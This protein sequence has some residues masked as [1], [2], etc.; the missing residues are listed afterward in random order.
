VMGTDASKSVVNPDFQVHG[1]QTLYIAD[2]SI[3]PNAPGINPGLTI[4]SL[5]HRLATQ[6]LK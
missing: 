1:E 4:K 2:S 5:G 3:Y 6:L